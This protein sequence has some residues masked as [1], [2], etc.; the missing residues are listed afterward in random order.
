MLCKAKEICSCSRGL[1]CDGDV[2]LSSNVIHNQVKYRIFFGNFEQFKTGNSFVNT[3][4]LQILVFQQ[5]FHIL[6]LS[7]HLSM[8]LYLQ[9]QFVIFK[10]LSYCFKETIW[11]EVKASLAS[12]PMSRLISWYNNQVIKQKNFDKRLFSSTGLF[13]D[14]KL[15]TGIENSSTVAEN[16][17]MIYFFLFTFC[18]FSFAIAY[19]LL[20]FFTFSF[21]SFCF[22][23]VHFHFLICRSFLGLSKWP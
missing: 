9:I 18:L 6:S 21:R 11:F 16:W 23:L 10:P 12:R 2:P 7:V 1:R 14:W 17:H 4:E 13:M 5:R 19:F 8:M 20:C 3:P 22:H 15:Q